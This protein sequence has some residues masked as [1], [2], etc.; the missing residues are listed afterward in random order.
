M[1]YKTK[2]FSN[3]IPLGK[4]ILPGNKRPCD[5]LPVKFVDL[6][7][8]SAINTRIWNVEYS[9]K[10]EK[11]ISEFPSF[12]RKRIKSIKRNLEKGYIYN[13]G[14]NIE[15]EETH[16]ISRYSKP[17]KYHRLTKDIN[18]HDRFDYIVYPPEVFT[19]EET[20]INYLVSKIVVQ[21]LKGHFDW[22]EEQLYS[23]KED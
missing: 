5:P 15:G 11:Q 14:G 4:V 16:Y 12:V 8:F 20:G 17:G 13:N 22:K 18:D 10:V 7:E 19:D 21:S 9:K 1:I 3:Q 23:E 2:R 6:P